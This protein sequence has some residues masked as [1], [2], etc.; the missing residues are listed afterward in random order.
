VPAKQ[1]WISKLQKREQPLCKIGQHRVKRATPT[2]ALERDVPCT[3]HPGGV[4]IL[5]TNV[6]QGCEGLLCTKEALRKR[7]SRGDTTDS[8]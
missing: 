8:S 7:D 1:R 4:P 3:M 2:S 5:C 6:L